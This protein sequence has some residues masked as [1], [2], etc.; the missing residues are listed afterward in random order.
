MIE[1]R[2]H[3][4]N[5]QRNE[6]FV[7][8]DVGTWSNLNC[9]KMAQE[10]DCEDLYNFAYTPFSQVA[11]SMWPHVSVYNMTRCKNPLHKHHLIPAL[12]DVPLDPDYLYRSCKYVDK[13]YRLFE[14]HFEVSIK[15]MPLDWWN[16]YWESIPIEED[17]K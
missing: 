14:K 9:R 5:S 17:V 15:L 3:W 12:L 10:A 7:E 13:T 16:N 2:E 6:F 11:H 4:I 8:V 1:F